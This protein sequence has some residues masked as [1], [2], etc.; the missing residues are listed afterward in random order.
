VKGLG[1]ALA[2]LTEHR[3]LYMLVA[4]GLFLFGVHSFVEA[5]WRR[6]RDEDVVQ[7][8]KNAAR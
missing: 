6:I 3:A 1:D 7:R 5:R 2:A 4:A 8:L